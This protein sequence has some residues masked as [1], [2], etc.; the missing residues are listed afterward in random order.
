MSPYFQ[1]QYI[2]TIEY[3]KFADIFLNNFEYFDTR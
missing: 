3:S 1:K 2:L